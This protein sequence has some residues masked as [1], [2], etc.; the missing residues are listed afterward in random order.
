MEF[1]FLERRK[2]V[3]ASPYP[4]FTLLGQSLGSLVLGFEALMKF[5]PDIY[6]DTMGYAFTIPL[7]RYLAGCPVACYV[8]YPTISTD[9]LECV[10]Q[11]TATYN[12]AGFIVRSPILS[13]LKI[14]YYRSF[15][16]VYGVVGNRSQIVMV[17][18]SWTEGHIQQIWSAT[19]RTHVVYP[20]CDT[21]Q[22]LR[23]P[24]TDKSTKTIQSIVS[25]AQFRP[26]KDHPLQIKAFNEFCT[27]QVNK[28]HKKY[29]LVLVG[30]CRNEEDSQRVESLKELAR[31]LGVEDQVEFRLNVSFSELKNT[32]K[33]A[34]VG[35][36]T[37]W[38]EHFGIGK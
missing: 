7:F 37:M 36:H 21:K 30:S 35:I 38:N 34:T 2:W 12:N 10:S 8:H 29:K 32:M 4:Y 14:W 15:A 11:R 1:V 26:E 18:S 22:F 25:V 17:N 19:D 24:L 9:M 20:P 23:I 13:S 33:D 5:V 16:Y 27:R 6:I 31:E 3:E 28:D